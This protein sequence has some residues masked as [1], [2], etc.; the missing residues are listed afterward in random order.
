MLT[1]KV[2]AFMNAELTSLAA[3]SRTAKLWVQFYRQVDIIH[4]FIRAERCGD[5]KLHLYA[6]QQ[7]LPYLH[8]TGHL[9]Y[10]EYAHMYL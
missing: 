7:M 6:V 10:A 3:V 1:N 9:H 5:W 4:L 8:A 2:V